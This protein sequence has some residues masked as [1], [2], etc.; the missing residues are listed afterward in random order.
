MPSMGT[1]RSL[2]VRAASRMFDRLDVSAVTKRIFVR[3]YL[4]FMWFM[5][6]WISDWERPV[7]IMQ[8]AP[9]WERASAVVAASSPWM[10]PA[11]RTV[12]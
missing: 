6:G 11:R 3:G 7:K 12:D 9:P 8:P 5:A 2:I 4:R 10:K 1:P